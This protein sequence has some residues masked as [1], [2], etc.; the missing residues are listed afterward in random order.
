MSG[1]T[2]RQSEATS[3]MTDNTMANENEQKDK[4]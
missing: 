1:D 4:Q 2:I 3:R